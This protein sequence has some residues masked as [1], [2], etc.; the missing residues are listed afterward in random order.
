MKILHIA[1]ECYPAAKAGGLGDVVGA[2]PKYQN[3]QGHHS[4][5]A[6]P[7]YKQPWIE[8]QLYERIYEGLIRLNEVYVPFNIQKTLNDD[9]GFQLYFVDIPGFF[10]RTGIYVDAQ[11][12]FGYA[13]EVERY[14]LFQQ[15]ILQWII[16]ESEEFEI[17]HCHDHHAALIP[18]MVKHCPEFKSLQWIPTILTI[19]NGMYHG[20]FRWDNFS[21]LPYFDSEA[22]SLLEWG[23]VV[24]PL[25][26]GI[27]CCWAFT[28]VS[29]GY[30]N[31]LTFSANGI[32]ALVKTEWHKANG[33]INGIDRDIW[34]PSTDPL[35]AFRLDDNLSIFKEKN[36]QALA[37]RFQ[38]SLKKPLITFIGRLVSEKG[39]D[40]LPNLIAS[41]MEAGIDANFVVLGTGD[42]V[43]KEQ[44]LAMKLH[45]SHYFDTSIEYNEALSHQLYAGSDFLIM[46]SRVEPCGLNQLYAYRYATIPI[47]RAVGGL[48][49]TVRD[50]GEANGTGIRFNQFS[51]EDALWAVR[52]AVE[53][54]HNTE[55]LNQTRQRILQL[56]YSWDQ[57]AQK[58]SALYQ[59]LAQ[60][61][62]Q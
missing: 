56:D 6:I 51:L 19:H 52:R 54:Y 46:P 3:I 31:E 47:V 43:L 16:V 37:Q 10:D 55:L 13:D 7:R 53:L 48:A 50:V 42:P 30:L 9:L 27:K 45:Y 18:F 33:I 21:L 8:K 2:L 34:N 38:I 61:A 41:C 36:K 40:L 25:A 62:N 12:G 15:A 22:Y 5:V 60:Y 39:A 26:C 11:S 57:S 49:D 1:A 14:L 29:P 32:E 58:Y 17:L 44:F 35:I 20:A 23:G 24:N 59:K 28:T 4:S